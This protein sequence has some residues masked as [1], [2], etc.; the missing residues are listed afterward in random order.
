[1][2]TPIF[3]GAN[4]LEMEQY[5]VSVSSS[6]PYDFPMYLYN[7]PQCASNDL[8]TAV[9][10]KVKDKCKN[11][12]GIK[13]SYPDFLRTNEYL[14]INGGDFS[15]MQGAD[16]LFLPALAMGCDGVISGVSCVYPEPFVAVYN[17]YLNKDLDKARELQRIAIQYCEVLKSGSNMSYFKEALKLRGIDAGFMRAPQL[18]LSEAEV[19]ELKRKLNELPAI[20]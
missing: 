8:K 7:I 12:V 2:V 11:V 13:Y 20:H 3:L 1:M 9:A 4:D 16:R 18:D 5:Y 14:S 15:V 17:A 6:I 19:N 10:Q